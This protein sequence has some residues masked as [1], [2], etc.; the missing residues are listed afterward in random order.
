[1]SRFDSIVVGN[2]L[3]SEHYLTA[4]FPARVRDL[5]KRWAEL[6]GYAKHTPRTGL[7]GLAS[8]LTGELVTLREAHPERRPDLLRALYER[9]RAAL[10]L[11]G[12]RVTWQFERPDGDA[13]VP[14]VVHRTPSGP[15]L[16]ILEAGDAATVED[17]L[18]PDGAGHLL[19]P[20][21]LADGTG[22]PLT[23][24][25]KVVQAVFLATHPAPPPLVAVHAGGWLLIAERERWA[26]GRWLA[27]DLAIAADR[28][29]TRAS[30]ELETIA[31]LAGREALLPA[32]DG[33]CGFTDL[34]SDA[35]THAVGVSKDLREGVRESIE[36]IATEVLRRRR[37]RGI[38]DDATPDLPRALTRQALRYLYRILF[39]LYAEARPELGVLPV[40]SP[41]YA[42]GY[43]LDR[44]RDLCLVE[45]TDPRSQDGRH[46]Y[47][48]LA[49]LFTR[50]DVG[51]APPDGGDDSLVFEPLRA[52]LF[53]TDAT[54]LIDEVGL[55]NAALQKVLARLLLSKKQAKKDRGF[56]SYAQL[57]I[58]QLGAV[59][60]G[61]MS[62]TGRIAE[63]DL[64]EV[65]RDGNPEKG[66]WLVPKRHFDGSGIDPALRVV[67][68]DPDTD[69]LRPV[70]Y[71]RGDFV[72]RLSG[73]D[74]QRSASY[75]T[76]QVLTACVVR[77]SLAELLDQP[78]PDG[79]PRRTGAADLLRLK[80]CEPA[81]GSGAFLV[82][83]IDQLAIEYLN[84]AQ[85]ERGEKVEDFQAEARKV[86]AYLALH[87]CYGVD[88]NETAVELA[89]ISLWLASM[90]QGLEAPWFGLR[91]RRGNSLIGAR[92]AFYSPAE[93]AKA[94]WWKTVPVDRSPALDAGDDG[95][96]RDG[97]VHHF[98]LPAEGW[99]AVADTKE[100]KELR[101][102]ETITLKEWRKAMRRAPSKADGK[103]LAAL[104][105]RV[106]TLWALATVRLQI[107]EA[108]SRRDIDVW[109][110]EDL[111][112]S[113]GKVSREQIEESLAKDDGA[114]RRLRRVMDAWAALWF[115]SVA[116]DVAPPTWEQWLSALEG[117]LGVEPPAATGTRKKRLAA[118]QSDIFDTEVTW[119]S[120]GDD[121]HNDLLFAGAQPV[122]EVLAEH[123]WLGECERVAEREGF[124]HWE[125]DFA[126]VFAAG[127]FDLQIGNPPWVRPD[128]E[129]DLVLAEADPWFALAVKP[130][131][132]DVARR[133]TGLLQYERQARSYLDERA[134]M[135]GTSAHL[136]STVDRPILDGLRPDLYRCFIERTWRS[137]AVKGTVG[138]IHPES[139][140]TEAR[141]G[142]F[143]QAVYE[144][145]RRHWQFRNV[146]KLFEDVDNG[147]E[148][149]VSVYGHRGNVDFLSA[150]SLFHPQTA[151]RSLE[152]DGTGETPGLRLE[153]SSWDMRPH[154]DRLVRVTDDVLSAWAQLIDEEGTPPRQARLLRPV[155]SESQHVLTRLARAPRFGEVDFHWTS[156]WNEKTD[157]ERG[158]FAAGWAR[159]NTWD[160]VILQGPHFTVAT[161][162]AKQPRETM[163]SNKDYDTWDLETLPERAIPLTSYQLARLLPDCR[164]GYPHWEGKCSAD[165]FRL[166][167][168]NMVDG[169]TERSLQAAIV[170]PGPTHVHAVH[171]LTTPNL[172]DLAVAAGLW[173][174]V[175]LD[176]FVKVSG[177][178]KVQ[179]ETARRF[180]HPASH[181]L[182]QELVLRVLRLNCL[183]LDYG[184]LWEEVFEDGWPSDSWTPIDAV[185]VPAPL[186][187]VQ[188][189]W[190][191][192]TPL[193]KDFDRRQALVEI[194]AL[195]AVML[196]IT[197]EE[198]CAIYRT[199][200][201]VL[202]K[203]ERQ[204][205][206]DANGRK[207]SAGVLKAYNVWVD[208]GEKGRRPDLGRYDPP[209]FALDREADMTR[210][211]EEFSHR[212]AEREAAGSEAVG[213]GRQ[214]PVRWPR[215]RGGW[216]GTPG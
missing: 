91:L 159:P 149:S 33:S 176:F 101:P 40:G 153:D 214:D 178:G 28:R 189:E 59:Y 197:A 146:L 75:Y 21:T 12:D 1:M 186:G 3:V 27:I 46:L 36:V 191:M 183:T 216:R 8:S 120:L 108:E 196:G 70:V 79:D 30:G 20:L 98:L 49:Q 60:E 190:T 13:V 29:D 157:R 42:A 83:A 122:A 39:L 162:F 51:Y 173:S 143:R 34:L 81:L 194:D 50:V 174:S 61:L 53:K 154:R 163:K 206:Y 109:G 204:N 164:A 71:R 123:P 168:R 82:E 26:E 170:P 195:A 198:L 124:F 73:R 201:G 68:L 113:R 133:R 188:R 9:A 92:R 119:E 171:T 205:R 166:V 151:D 152:H 105:R 94:L 169:S 15:H 87:C 56:V 209:F 155:N 160:E 100:A 137:A 17:V 136:G 67:R 210:A 208:R 5:R 52:D 110:A 132:Q 93:Y 139:H 88:L 193:R 78:G 126:P 165:F 185:Y 116:S 10:G 114:Y 41:E 199:Q 31:A 90:H 179:A 103:R 141:A 14:A 131:V 85:A 18:D 16:V 76:P 48:S 24:T 2:E 215:G 54:A 181:S 86:K 111:P 121:E 147:G 69:Q 161:P 118:G 184:P 187:D 64:Y 200:F 89:E 43:G 150:V 23:I 7:G 66:S 142:A 192:G 102:D 134:S 62:Y 130:P 128:W 112:A 65:A 125:L 72:L 96:L 63:E 129:D 212:L 22:Q 32:D 6:E 104:A 25:K 180:P 148:F 106:E 156:G 177:V 37:A 47:L 77:H 182:V 145:L 203:Y 4:E 115:W 44:L 45:L 11:D 140:F 117:L 35:V 84:R 144:H 158:Y 167:W 95:V 175:V 138:L 107:A 127:G 74:R 202:R 38:P 19:D 80:I 207:V 97:E 135:A 211:H 213:G 58:N 57:G 55:G 99:G 172:L